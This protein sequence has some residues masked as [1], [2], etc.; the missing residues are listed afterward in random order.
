MMQSMNASVN[1]GKES[2]NMAGTVESKGLASIGIKV[3]IGG[4]ELNYVTSIPEL[5]VAPTALDSTTLKDTTTTS[6]PGVQE[7]KDLE[8]GILYDNKN[9]QSDFRVLKEYEK[10]KTAKE[11]EVE[12]PD[13]TVFAYDAMIS[14]RTN[15]AKVNEL[16]GATVT[17]NPQTGIEIT[18][19]TVVSE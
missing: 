17:T 7:L 9:A 5:G 6:T 4:K 10:S 8:Y 16:L 13:G 19:P 1:K 3:R 12:F 18:N 2:D 14:V 15:A 11:V